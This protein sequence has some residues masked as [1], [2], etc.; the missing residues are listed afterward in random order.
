MEL[1]TYGLP[2]ESD[3]ICRISSNAVDKYYRVGIKRLSVF[4]IME[5]SK[6]TKQ[7]L[8]FIDN[9]DIVWTNGNLLPIDAVKIWKYAK[10]Q[11]KKVIHT[12]RD[13]YFLGENK[14]SNKLFNNYIKKHY[15]KG[16]KFVDVF[17][18][19]SKYT[20]KKHYDFGRIKIIPNTVGCNFNKYEFNKLLLDKYKT[21]SFFKIIFVGRLSR[22]KGFDLFIEIINRL[23]EMKN[24]EVSVV[25]DGELRHLIPNFVDYKGKLSHMDT[26]KE[27]KKSHFLFLPSTIP[28]SFGRTLIEASFN[29]CLPLGMKI[30][31]IPEVI[32]NELCFNSVLE[33]VDKINKINREEWF[34]KLYNLPKEKYQLK[35]HIKNFSVL[36]EE[37]VNYE[38]AFHR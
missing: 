3:E 2:S 17:T 14:L 19:P 24:I 36:L 20:A 33:A 27:I 13:N 38:S 32:G 34:L 12:I 37:V 22:E 10:S 9:Y 31:A 28:E 4:E 23:K 1:L 26:I 5:F 7:I 30:G 18:A 29:A 25:G 15:I 8:D 16:S 35:T 21:F 6:V 11:G